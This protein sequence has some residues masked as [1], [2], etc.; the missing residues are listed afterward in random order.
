MKE[1]AF[2]SRYVLVIETDKPTTKNPGRIHYFYEAMATKRQAQ[3]ELDHFLELNKKAK[4]K[5][6]FIVDQ[7]KQPDFVFHDNQLSSY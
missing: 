7:E 4:N 6:A 2:V 3:Q 5:R 1:R